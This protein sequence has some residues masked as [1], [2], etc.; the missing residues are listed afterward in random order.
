M[1]I[2]P[3]TAIAR[4]KKENWQL[5]AALGYSIP[6]ALERA[7]EPN[8]YRCGICESRR[9]YPHLQG[10]RDPEG[11]RTLPVNPTVE[12]AQAAIDLEAVGSK[13]TI[14]DAAAIYHAMVTTVVKRLNG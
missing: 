5:R 6:A 12:Q 13:I 10:S 11:W 3:W 9:L 7:V 8:P 2:W 1:K 14:S 4:L